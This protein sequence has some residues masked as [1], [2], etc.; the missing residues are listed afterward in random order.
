MK[1]RI[2]V[3][4][5]LL[6]TVTIFSSFTTKPLLPTNLRITV[7]DDIGNVVE[8]ASVTLY[9]SEEDYFEEKKPV[10]ETQKTDAKGRVTFKK[11]EPIQYFVHAQKGDKDNVGDGVSISKL[12][13]GRINLVNTIIRK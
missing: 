8:G 10:R 13:E 12:K 9:A 5:A 3:A 1:K 2:S 6:I 7:L 11:L 4:L